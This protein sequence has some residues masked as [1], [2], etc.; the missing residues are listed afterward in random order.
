MVVKLKK[1]THSIFNSTYKPASF[2]PEDIVEIH[3]YK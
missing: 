1:E 3:I 2:L